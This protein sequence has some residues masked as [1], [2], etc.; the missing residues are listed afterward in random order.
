MDRL[1][2]SRA[3]VSVRKTEEGS[4]HGRRKSKLKGGG[5]GTGDGRGIKSGGSR[6]GPEDDL[7]RGEEERDVVVSELEQETNDL[8]DDTE[9]DRKSNSKSDVPSGKV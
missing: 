6:W 8:R 7:T 3:R 5:T 4:T 2:A 9:E 1:L